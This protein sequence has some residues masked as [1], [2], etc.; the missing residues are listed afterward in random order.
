MASGDL[1]NELRGAIRVRQLAVTTER[2]YVSWYRR[3][4]L[5]HG[6]KHPAEMGAKE[7]GEFLTFLAREREV[8]AATQV[9]AL[10]ALVF[11]YREVLKT[12]LEDI[13]AYR[14]KRKRKIPVAL[15]ADAMKRLLAGLEGV[16]K[17]MGQLMY[18]CG[19]RINECVSLRV[20]NLDIAEGVIRITNAKGG[21]QRILSLPNSLRDPMVSQ[22]GSAKALYDKDRLDGLNGVELPGAIGRGFGNPSESW[23]WYWVFPSPVLS[24]D[25]RSGIVRRHHAHPGSFGNSLRE[26]VKKLGLPQRVSAH[27]LRH[28]Y[29]TEML[30]MGTDLR[31]LQEAMGHSSVKTTEVYTHVLHAM[32]GELPNPLD[33]MENTGTK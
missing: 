5:F 18:G 33:A 7:V 20:H 4:V 19:I 15:G 17:M 23:N 9:Q 12:K 16:N 24:E 14:A 21:K 29:A 11:L 3:F 2:C 26:A 1:E 30:R 25:P 32:R 10:N 28:S 22:L 8:A 27:T 13:E 6:K 31:S